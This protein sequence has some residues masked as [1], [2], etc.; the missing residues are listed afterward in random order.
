M[1]S[2][3]P[4]LALTALLL[5]VALAG[6]AVAAPEGAAAPP[7]AAT[8]E[9]AAAAQAVAVT[10]PQS[11]AELATRLADLPRTLSGWQ[12][13]GPAQSCDAASLARE[14]PAE[15]ALAGDY[16]FRWGLTVR[17]LPP[18]PSREIVARLL[19]FAEDLDAFGFFSRRRTAE[20]AAAQVTVQS[21]WLGPQLCIWRGPVVLCLTPRADDK[22]VR[23][24]VLAAGQ[25]LVEYLP[26]PRQLPLLMRLMPQGRNLPQTLRYCR[27][28][29]LGQPALGDGLVDTYLDNPGTLTL[30][31]LRA[32]DETA[33]RRLYDTLQGLLAGEAPPQ[34]VVDLGQA[35]AVLSSHQ[36]GLCLTMREG[37]YVVAAVGVHDRRTAEGLLQI[38]GTNIR[39]S[40]LSP[41]H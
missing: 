8:A 26:L 24:A 3:R 19:V 13:A 28:A 32:G 17:L 25:A 15:A 11:P 9:P 22:V 20:A 21:F 35:A 16:D 12:F 37:A 6:V 10:L 39:L 27:H 34:P 23:A 18:P 4:H 33:A 31:L 14:A 36:F 5:W 41:S 29:V 1:E 40:R 2:T 38:A 7:S 30:A